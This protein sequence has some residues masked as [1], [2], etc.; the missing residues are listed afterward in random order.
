[1]VKIVTQ[2][3]SIEGLKGYKKNNPSKFS[4]KFG[5]LDLDNI[6]KEYMKVRK[7]QVGEREWKDEEYFDSIAYRKFII[8]G[9]PETPLMPEFQSN[10][11][12]PAYKA[13]VVEKKEEV[14][15]EAPASKIGE[16]FNDEKS[17][18]IPEDVN[19]ESNLSNNRT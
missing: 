2:P 12:A 1:M 15:V 18:V 4:D 5:D 3:V 6:P 7:V 17:D 9:K 13:P 19:L 11:V 8:S 14:K 16:G 10:Y